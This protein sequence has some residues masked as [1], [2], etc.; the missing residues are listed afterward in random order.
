MN[1]KLKPVVN[2]IQSF[3][4]SFPLTTPVLLSIPL[5]IIAS[6]AQLIGDRLLERIVITLFINLVL[7]LGLQIFMGNSG[8]LSFAHIG[9]MGIGAYASVIFSM[10]PQAKAIGLKDLYPF[11]QPVH[12]PFIVSL[13]LGGLI[14]L[15]V[16][17]I[18]SYPLMRLSDAAAVITTFA[19]LVIIHVVLVH[20]DNV[21][22]GPQTLFG[23]DR[24]TYLWNSV[25]WGILFVF[26][27][28]WFK[29]SS[30][31]LKLRASQDDEYAAS[32]SGVNIIQMRWLAFTLSAFVAGIGGGLWAHFITS[33]SPKAFYL[34]ETFVILAM[35]I[36]GGP[37]G[38][39]GA[40]VGTI[41]V[42]FIREGLRL[43][44]NAVNISQQ[45]GG[46][47]V[48]VTEVFLATALIFLLILRPAGILGGREV[49]LGRLK[50]GTRETKEVIEQ[51]ANVKG[52]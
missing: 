31:G 45:F 1:E 12:L 22:N 32:T 3:T 18:I 50:Y 7:V 33:F 41:L 24:Y 39:S 14:A 28:Y 27:A 29:E 9:F 4:A 30:Y 47:V 49:R 5:V 11:L 37:R 51:T 42:T 15:F 20:W 6:V 25:A 21:T 38:V 40:V 10:T 13:L 35:L 36:V 43:M 8:I 26:I 34:T 52:A 23:V 16:A 46:T 17:A 44:E 2:A 48:G 19:L